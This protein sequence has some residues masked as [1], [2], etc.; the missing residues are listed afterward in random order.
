MHSLVLLVLPLVLLVALL[1]VLPPVLMFLLP[2]LQPQ[3]PHPP[4]AQQAVQAPSHSALQL[5]LPQASTRAADVATRWGSDSLAG[6]QGARA[7][8]GTWGDNGAVTTPLDAHLGSAWQWVEV[9]AL[10]LLLLV[11]AEVVLVVVV[12]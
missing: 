3:V 1:L 8:W 11:V 6:R 2:S 7:P 12:H 4:A 10:A 5:L 9:Q